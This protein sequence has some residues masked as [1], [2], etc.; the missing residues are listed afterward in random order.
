MPSLQPQII[1][2]FIFVKRIHWCVTILIAD[3]FQ[4]AGLS[5]FSNNWFNIHDFTPIAGEANW[6]LLPET[7]TVDHY[8]PFPNTEEFNSVNIS[9]NADEFVVPVTR[10]SR[11]KK[12]DEV[13]C[14]Y[15]C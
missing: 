12:Y 10:G 14:F 7:A 13:S 1:Q 3:Q 15:F 2:T 5:L 4:K 9:S 11:E 8:V 6:S